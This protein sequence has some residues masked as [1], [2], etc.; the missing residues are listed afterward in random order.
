MNRVTHMLATAVLAAVVFSC[1]VRCELYFA[2]RVVIGLAVPSSGPK[3]ELGQR[4]RTAAG[5]LTGVPLMIEDDGCSTEG[6]RAAAARFVAAQVTFVFGHPCSNAAIAAAPIYAAAGIIFVAVGARHPALTDKRAGPAVFRIGGRDDRQIAATVGAFAVQFR[7]KRVAF[8]HDRTA[9]AKELA[10]GIAAGFKSSGVGDVINSSI[11][12]GEKDY[13]ALVNQLVDAKIDALYFA[14]FPTEAELIFK[15]LAQSGKHIFYFGC[16]ALADAK[17]AAAWAMYDVQIA[18]QPDLS[19]AHLQELLTVW[20]SG[21]ASARSN[22]SP[23]DVATALGAD[24]KGDAA[25][26]SFLFNGN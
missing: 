12:A 24:A 9:Y 8:V 19:T 17:Y 14:G 2:E 23:A 22:P 13:G 10:E 11:I 1:P 16:D 6:G 5:R 26:P 25:G 18:R 7:G 3:A 4:L 21:S 15:G 20:F